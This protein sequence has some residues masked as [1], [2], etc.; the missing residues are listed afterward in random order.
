[1]SSPAFRVYCAIA[2]IALEEAQTTNLGIITD[3]FKTICARQQL[4][5]DGEIARKAIDAVVHVR[6]KRRA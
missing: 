6:A 2:G 1:M 5:Y 4:R 3:H